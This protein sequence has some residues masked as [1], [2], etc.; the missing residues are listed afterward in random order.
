MKTHRMVAALLAL[1][2]VLAACGSGTSTTTTAGDG[3]TTTGDGSTPSTEPSGQFKEVVIL[4]SGD[5]PDF[6]PHTSGA[7]EKS[8]V[9][10]NVYDSLTMLNADQ[11]E[12]SMIV[13]RIRST[14]TA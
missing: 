6:D 3:P 2:M 9:T 7:T 14:S 10:H 12:P 4:A 11:T 1:A 5:P 13:W 8:N